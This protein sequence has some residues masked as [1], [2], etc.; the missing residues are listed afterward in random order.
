MF[1]IAPLKL[2]GF[3]NWFIG[4]VWENKIQG[5]VNTGISCRI[6]LQVW[7][8]MSSPQRIYSDVGIRRYLV[9]G[10]YKLPTTNLH[11]YI[12]RNSSGKNFCRRHFFIAITPE[13]GGN[14][15]NLQNC[16]N[17]KK[18]PESGLSHNGF[19]ML[20]RPVI[21]NQVCLWVPK[22]YVMNWS[23]QW[24]WAGHASRF[25]FETAVSPLWPTLW[26]KYLV[27]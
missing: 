19:I 20:L 23:F 5:A 6:S 17:L 9:F 7:D 26:L 22:R 1:K 21:L 16:R 11:I 27:M 2:I 18:T 15:G 8:W 4:V 13:D 24:V 25:G 14:A 10:V 12:P 3:Q